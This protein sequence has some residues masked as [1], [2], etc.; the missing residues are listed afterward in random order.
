MTFSRKNRQTNKIDQSPTLSQKFSS[1][2][3]PTPRV[4]APR[5]KSPKVFQAEE[6]FKELAEAY[7]I[8]SN[9]E[10]RKQYDLAA[11]F[12]GDQKREIREGGRSGTWNDCGRRILIGL[13]NSKMHSPAAVC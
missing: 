2:V 5:M 12:T 13:Y 7:S 4:A 1:H 6:K 3:Q 8:L 10:K 9:S 11:R